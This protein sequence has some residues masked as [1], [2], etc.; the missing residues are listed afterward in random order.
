MQFPDCLQKYLLNAVL[1]L[2]FIFQVFHTHT[3]QQQ[4]IALKQ[5][6]QPC[7]VLVLVKA[8]QQLLVFNMIVSS[9]R[10]D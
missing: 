3:E 1:C 4:G 10:Q 8:L 2:L 9:G 5:D 6:S 7:I